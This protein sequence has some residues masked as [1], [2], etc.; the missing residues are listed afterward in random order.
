M[1][2]R[3][4]LEITPEEENAVFEILGEYRK[5]VN[6]KRINLKP[7]FQDFDITNNSHVTKMQFSRV[8]TQLGIIASDSTMNL[9]LKRYMD[10]GNVDEINYVDFCNEIDTPENMFGVGRDYNN[11]Y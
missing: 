3:K 5:A 4:Y 8:L 6:N 1:A 10:K 7:L 2:R 9:V 11:S